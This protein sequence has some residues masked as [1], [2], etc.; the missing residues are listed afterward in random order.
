MIQQL[1]SERLSGDITCVAG[2]EQFSGTAPVL[3]LTSIVCVSAVPPASAE[4]CFSP[5]DP[6]TVLKTH[7]SVTLPTDKRSSRRGFTM[8]QFCLLYH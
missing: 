2:F 5:D 3:L 4:T 8:T 6:V 7:Y 1:W